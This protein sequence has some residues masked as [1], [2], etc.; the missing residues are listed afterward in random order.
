[1]KIT[2]RFLFR[3]ITRARVWIY[4]LRAYKIVLWF[5]VCARFLS[6]NFYDANQ[7]KQY[8]ILLWRG[9]FFV[10]KKCFH[11]E[12]EGHAWRHFTVY[13][14]NIYLLLFFF[15][16]KINSLLWF[17]FIRMFISEWALNGSFIER[18]GR[19][20]SIWWHVFDIIRSM[21]DQMQ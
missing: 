20:M 5:Y 1:M 13:I 4:I 21:S 14:E 19:V 11:I 18:P 16:W 10:T 7:G 12:I 6:I 2:I 3:N 17:A 8:L 15:C 9:I